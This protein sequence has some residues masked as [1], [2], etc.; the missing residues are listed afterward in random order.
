MPARSFTVRGDRWRL[1]RALVVAGAVTVATTAATAASASPI[2]TAD[3]RPAA[4]PAATPRTALP[5]MTAAP[6][7]AF[8]GARH[9][10][11][12]ALLDTNTHW[13][14]HTWYAGPAPATRPR[15]APRATT[16]STDAP[17]PLLAADL[18][19]AYRLPSALLG[20]RQTIAIV[21]AFDAPNVEADLA[22]YRAANKLPA[23]DSSFPCFTKV[24]QRGEQG[25]YPPADPGWS[26]E[27][28]TDVDMASAICPNC[29]LLLVE[30]D[31]TS[32]D[33]LGAAVD[34]AVKLGADVV[35]NSYGAP[36]WPAL[37]EATLTELA[38]HYNHPG[39]VLTA[40]SGDGGFGVNFP[41]AF[42]T[43]IAV[44]GTALYRDNNNPRGWS[45][46][47]WLGAGSGCSAY[48]TKPAWQKDRLCDKRTVTDVAAVADV[49]TPVAVYDTFGLDGWV[50][51][52]GTSVGAPIIAAVYALAGNT[53]SITPGP[54]LYAH[55]SDLFD[56]TAGFEGAPGSN[57][58]CGDSYLCTAG[59]GYDGPTGTGTPNGIGAF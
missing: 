24:N 10:T 42:K 19:A 11:C 36:E 26:L 38:T 5:Q 49:A 50:A 58:M 22:A 8:P 41:A 39:V 28:S 9:V 23:C 20:G 30:A 46:T 15:T 27:A 4:N 37:D 48:T 47:A 43:V 54:F 7:C 55:Q 56:V 31:D 59:Q 32:T 13:N 6:A 33:S 34:E 51:V 1:R 45:E 21:D 44:G 53:R 57:G 12:L 14:G 2:L 52:G 18:Q 40:A 16:A 25:N 35:S 17:A 3:P 29:Q